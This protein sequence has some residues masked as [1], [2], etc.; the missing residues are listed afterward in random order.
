MVDLFFISTSK[1]NISIM[2]DAPGVST[3]LNR[4]FC[5]FLLQRANSQFVIIVF[6]HIICTHHCVFAI[7]CYCLAGVPYASIVCFFLKKNNRK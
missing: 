2:E 1:I 4:V 3:F 7:H 5:H 6:S